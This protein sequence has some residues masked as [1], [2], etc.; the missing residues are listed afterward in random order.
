MT[1]EQFRD[2]VDEEIRNLSVEQKIRFAWLCAVR[3]TP[4]LG[5]HKCFDYWALKDRY[6]YL[7]SIFHA[8]DVVASFSHT[9]I[10]YEQDDD[11]KN[12][13]DSYAYRAARAVV[14]AENSATILNNAPSLS[15]AHN[16]IYATVYAAEAADYAS[17]GAS[18]SKKRKNFIKMTSRTVYGASFAYSASIDKDAFAKIILADIEAIRTNNPSLH[19][20]YT[21]LYGELW[22]EF[23]SY[24]I[25]LGFVQA[26]QH[27]EELFLNHFQSSNF[28]FL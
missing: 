24:L 6:H 1:V 17:W 23:L 7:T 19:N 20:N 8:L 3:A 4:F 13:G 10:A 22:D 27:F 25:A 9:R 5:L 18:D 28:T 14:E 2:T 11:S 12:Y 21:S 26:S 16:A 15:F